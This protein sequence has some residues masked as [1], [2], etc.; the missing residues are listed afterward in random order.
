MTVATPPL[1]WKLLVTP[2]GG[3]EEPEDL[4]LVRL[5]G[6]E[7]GAFLVDPGAHGKPGLEI[8]RRVE[9]ALPGDPADLYL[10]LHRKLAGSAG[11]SLAMLRILPAEGVVH[12]SGVGTI[13]GLIVS[14]GAHR[15]RSAA[16]V[17]GVGLP[18]PPV[19]LEARWGPGSWAILASDGLVEGWDLDR[20]R[21]HP[22]RSIDGLVH[23]IRQLGPRL[24]DDASM[25]L[26]GEP[27]DARAPVAAHRRSGRQRS[28]PGADSR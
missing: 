24:P 28:L 18:V 25:L 12:F 15:F 4:G 7:V 23:R 19:R 6:R 2:L 21:L 16:G 13:R 10:R 14:S 17:L 3:L 8:R 26:I 20:L 11:A 9:Q 22:F 5:D 1:Q 27:A